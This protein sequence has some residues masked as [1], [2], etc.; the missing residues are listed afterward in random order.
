MAFLKTYWKTNSY[1]LIS[2]GILMLIYIVLSFFKEKFIFA[3]SGTGGIGEEKSAMYLYFFIIMIVGVSLIYGLMAFLN[4]KIHF[5][6]KYLH[7]N[8][9][10]LSIIISYVY[11]NWIGTT[12]GLHI[13]EEQ[14]RIDQMIL[15]W[16]R[17]RMSIFINLSVFIFWLA[18]LLF[19]TNII[20]AVNS[21]KKQIITLELDDTDHLVT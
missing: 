8:L 1:L 9:T 4:G 10:L 6:L 17:L 18:Q 15:Q 19:L 2:S 14:E 20:R 5:H 13:Y 21:N 3:I 11:F 12:V 7:I 16:F